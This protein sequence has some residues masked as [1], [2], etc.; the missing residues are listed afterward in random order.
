MDDRVCQCVGISA[1]IVF[2][3]P[4]VIIM[5]FYI[6]ISLIQVVIGLLL[7]GSFHASKHVNKNYQITLNHHNGLCIVTQL[8]PQVI[9]VRLIIFTD[10]S[11]YSMSRITLPFIQLV[12]L[13]SPS[14]VQHNTERD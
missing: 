13:P 8:N 1:Y 2:A 5:Q 11:L 3:L 10:N 4:C 6:F 12:T 7:N 14:T 9:I